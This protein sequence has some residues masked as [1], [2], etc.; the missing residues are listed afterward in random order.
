M[1]I[2]VR[3]ESRLEGLV[4]ER[5]Q[6]TRPTNPNFDPTDPNGPHLAG[7]AGLLGHGNMHILAGGLGGLG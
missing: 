2:D 6:P 1:L 3:S 7:P 5:I 4:R